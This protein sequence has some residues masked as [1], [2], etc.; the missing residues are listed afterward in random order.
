MPAKKV[1]TKEKIIDGAMRFIEMYGGASL[2][3][4]ALAKYLSCS[5]QPIYLSFSSMEELK[6]ILIE[7]C[8]EVYYGYVRESFSKHTTVFAVYTFSYV[9]FAYERPRLFE[10][11]YMIN[12]YRNTEGDREFVDKVVDSVMRAGGYDRE[13]AHKFYLQSWIYAHGVATQIVTGYVEWELSVIEQLMLDEFNALKLLYSKE[14][15]HGGN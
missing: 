13:T 5:T 4:R 12:R 14:G 8:M 1:I 3:A 9:R 7:K 6:N 10:Y 2:N 11:V 15:D